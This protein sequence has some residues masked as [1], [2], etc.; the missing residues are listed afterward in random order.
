[1][2]IIIQQQSTITK[3]EIQDFFKPAEQLYDYDIQSRNG[4]KRSYHKENSNEAANA[5]KARL[6]LVQSPGFT[7]ISSSANRK[8]SARPIFSETGV[9]EIVEEG[10]IQLMA[11]QDEYS[12]KGSALLRKS[13][14]KCGNNT[15]A[16]QKHE[17]MSYG[18]MVKANNDVP[19]ELLEQFNIPTSP[20][21]FRGDVDNQNV[22][23]HFVKSI[24]EIAKNI[25]KLLQTNIPITF[26]AE[27]QQAHNLCKTCKLCKNGFSVG[28]HKVADHCNLSGKFRQTLCNTCNLKLQTP[29]FV[30]CFFHNLSNYDAHFIVTELGL[31]MKKNSVI[32]T[33]KKNSFHFQN[34]LSTLS[35]NLLTPGF[36]KFRETAKHF[37]AKD[38]PLVTRK[39]VYPYEY[40]DGWNKLEQ[41]HLPKKADFYSTLTESHIQEEDY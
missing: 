21:I 24:V 5:K 14:E 31:D 38:L 23:E 33:V 2:N 39:G 1:S 26:T 19:V 9:R 6:L 15:K 13:D 12:S 10:I 25:E 30:P 29:N 27:Q 32:P 8:T 22:R 7:A 28:N 3:R 35:E 11:E 4:H 20:K 34:T 16:I 41:I 36:E 37:N 17:A 18:F 40:T